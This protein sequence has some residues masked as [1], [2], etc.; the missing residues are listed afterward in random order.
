MA[1]SVKRIHVAGLPVAVLV[2]A[3][4]VLAALFLSCLMG[5]TSEL[6]LSS[7]VAPSEGYVPPFETMQLDASLLG[8]SLEPATEPY[9]RE[10]YRNNPL[11]SDEEPASIPMA[12]WLL[13]GGFVAVMLEFAAGKEGDVKEG[14]R[15]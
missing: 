7:M 5:C 1:K 9:A 13:F 2:L 4:P 6:A 8:M 15:P 12:A 10:P 11:N 14:E 3:V